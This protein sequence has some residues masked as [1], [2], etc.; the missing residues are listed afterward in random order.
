[1]L[2]WV[3]TGEKVVRAV[4]HME[5]LREGLGPED[6]DFARLPRPAEPDPS[7]RR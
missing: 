2:E 5:T 6:L 1:M 3:A 4:K 7:R